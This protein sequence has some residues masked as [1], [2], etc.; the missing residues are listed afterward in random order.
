MPLQLLFPKEF[1]LVH[2]VELVALPLLALQ[3]ELLEQLGQ[4]ERVVL[5]QVQL[6]ELGVVEPLAFLLLVE[7]LELGLEP[8]LAQL[9]KLLEH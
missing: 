3:L 9:G 5:E 6:L 8:P 4:L 2:Q 7:V 1:S